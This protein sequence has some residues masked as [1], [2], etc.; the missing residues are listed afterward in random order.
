M[1]DLNPCYKKKILLNW[2]YFI[3]F[4]K[5]FEDLWTKAPIGSL[6]SKGF[7]Q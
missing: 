6:I 5:A 7:I 2:Y 1:K 4:N 3:D